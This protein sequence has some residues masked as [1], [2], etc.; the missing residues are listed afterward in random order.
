MRDY[1]I[2]GL[3]AHDESSIL[4]TVCEESGTASASE[5][6]SGDILEEPATVLYGSR[7]EQRPTRSTPDK[8]FAYQ[9]KHAGAHDG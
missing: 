9:R 5:E 4:C 2:I 1:R 3:D 8:S 6:R 7:G